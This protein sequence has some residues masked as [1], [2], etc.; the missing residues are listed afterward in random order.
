M[1]QP[2][3]IPQAIFF[4]LQFFIPLLFV[5]SMLRAELPYLNL[6]ALVV[7]TNITILIAGLLTFLIPVVGLIIAYISGVE[8]EQYGYINHY[9][10]PMGMF[11]W[12]GLLTQVI[13]PQ[14]MWN[15]AIRRSIVSGCIWL[16]TYWIFKLANTLL[17]KYIVGSSWVT[18]TPD[19][20]L[21]DYAGEALIFLMV[22]VPVYFLADIKYKRARY[23]NR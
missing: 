16:V 20:H 17:L 15:K 8:Y 23:P 5:V 4:C 21:V 13:I 18:F 2:E 19:K 9:I 10:G 1:M 14:M 22:I 6:K 11:A 3:L 12:L 7:A